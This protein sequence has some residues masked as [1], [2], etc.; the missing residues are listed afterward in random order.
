[1]PHIYA[2]GDILEEKWELTPV[3]IQAGK[4]LARRLYSG[5]K[6]KVDGADRR[7]LLHKYQRYVNEGL[8]GEMKLRCSALFLFLQCDYVNVPTTVF[9]PMEY[10]ACGLSEER[11][12]GLYGQENIE[13]TCA[14]DCVN[15][16]LQP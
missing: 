7:H 1:M 15:N 8:T 13:V 12:V 16:S 10:G 5:S 2:I 4:L 11:A 3:A 6:V 14:L 9:T